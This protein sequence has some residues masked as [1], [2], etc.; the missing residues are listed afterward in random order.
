[1]KSFLLYDSLDLSCSVINCIL[2]NVFGFCNS[3]Y[4]I[5]SAINIFYSHFTR[6]AL[7]YGIQLY[8]T[9]CFFVQNLCDLHA[10][11]NLLDF[12]VATYR[13]IHYLGGT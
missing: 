2:L 10:L 11:G 3:F 13:T 7:L 9:K 12:P 8:Q 4:C 5:D 1:M 6:S